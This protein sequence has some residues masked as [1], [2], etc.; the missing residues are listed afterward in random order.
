MGAIVSVLEK[1]MGFCYRVCGNYGFAIILFTVLS[2]VI[3]LP[4]AV[5]LHK[6]GIKV[7]KMQPE[8]N[9][10][11]A[12]FYGDK[13]TIAEEEAK[14]Y[15]REHYHPLASII[16]LMVQI[17]IL[18]GLIAVIRKGIG[19]PDI[20][21]NFFGLDLSIVPAQ[22]GG[23]Y[24]LAPLIAGLSS[25]V[26]CLVQ[27]RI[28]PLQAEQSNFEKYFTMAVS[29][30]L[31]LY[32]GV[33]VA[34]GVVLYWVCSNLWAVGQQAVLNKVIDPKKSID[35][36]ALEE[37]KEALK[38]L[39]EVG[40][41]KDKRSRE[42]VRREKEDYKRFFSVVNKHLVFYSESSGFYKYFRGTVEYLLANTN[43]TIHYITSDPND[44]IFQIAKEQDRIRPYYIGENRLIT[45]M[46]KLDT[47]VMV[48]TM[49]DLENYHIKRSYVRK[50]IEYIFIPHSYNSQNLTL[51]KGAL[52]HFDTI[53]CTGKHQVEEMRKIEAAYGLPERELVHWGHT[54]IDDMRRDY[55]KEQEA[56]HGSQGTSP[57]VSNA[58]DGASAG[59][60][61]GAFEKAAA[62][63]TGRS[64]S[65]RPY[66]LVAPSW[67]EDCIMDSCLEEILDQ[68]KQTDYEIVVR[69]HPQYV[70]HK[71]ERCEMLKKRYEGT[72]I[73]VVTDFSSNKTV[74]NADVLI[75]DW[76]SI[77]LEYTFTTMKPVLYINTKM[78]V[79]NPEYQKID[80]VPLD[81][82][83]CDIIGISL[84][85]DELGRVNESVRKMI[86]EKETF[87]QPVEQFLQ[88]Y[89]YNLD[90]SA[91]VGANYIIGQLQKKQKEKKAQK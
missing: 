45:L 40:G 27:N 51:R 66:V 18:I 75:T 10:I 70:R 36:A 52:D 37:S 54:L 56:L 67:Q 32:L 50:D 63:D 33:F 58:S 89:I 28:N 13:D 43:L 39:G 71:G 87:D 1:I 78:K 15:K 24:L 23:L 76:S 42:L 21:M 17:L 80:T 4:L 25:F 26:L 82:L 68:L 22:K 7:V 61:A 6:N 5:Y 55:R 85:K 41:K 46:M 20:D 49:P 86:E 2:K 29:V 53:F 44:V 88:D 79:M 14:L 8:L 12:K 62:A 84:N 74:Y 34:L 59:Q 30:G 90:H 31:S 38:A 57:S 35:Y 16:P 3:L 73:E 72:N 47:D 48:M 83:A 9:Q 77:G 81:I 60:A 65:S 64:A 91:P 11:K 69:P 19:N